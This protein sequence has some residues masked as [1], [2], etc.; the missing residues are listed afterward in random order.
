MSAVK[1]QIIIRY[2]AFLSIVF[3]QMVI[4]GWYCDI[5]L[6]KSIIP[7]Y[8]SMKLNTAIGLLLS[9]IV[10][11]LLQRE[12]RLWGLIANLISIF[13]FILGFTTLLQYILNVDFKIDELL[14]SDMDTRM[15]SGINPGRMSYSTAVCLSLFGLAFLGIRM[16]NKVAKLIAQNLL[17]AITLMTFIALI[18]YIYVIPAFYKWSFLTSMALHTATVMFILSIAASLFNPHFGTTGLFTRTMIGNTMARKL[19]PMMLAMVL[20]LGYL[21]LISHK[22]NLVSVEFGIALYGLSFLLVG[23]LLIAVTARML[24]NSDKKRSEAE[25]QL[26]QLN[27]NLEVTIRKRTTELEQSLQL[28]EESAQRNKIFVTQSPNAIAMFDNDM[29]YLAA[30]GKWYEDYQIIGRDIIGKS[31]YDVF[32]EIGDD[33]KAIHKDCLKGG[34]NKCD[35]AYF[36]RGD[37]AEQWITW[38]VR[39]WYESENK[40][41]GIIMY[42]AEI[43]DIK[44]KEIDKR[45]IE[46]ILH[47]SNS[48]ALIG[49]WESNLLTGQNTWSDICKDIFEVPFDFEPQMY[50]IVD[51]IKHKDQKAEL[52]VAI[53]E[54]IE[55]ETFYDMECEIVTH[56]GR[57]GWV[58]IIGQS[59]SVNNVTIKHFGLIQD[60]TLQK[61]IEGK[62]SISEE[63][64]RGAFEN[65][66]IGIALVSTE[67]K[68]LKINEK[69]SG[70]LGYSKEELLATTFQEITHPDDLELDLSKMHQLLNGEINKYSI[71][72][73]YFKK[74]GQIIW[75]LLNVSL[76]RDADN[77]PLHF[78]SQIE[79]I[80]VR[81]EIEK[82]L[83]D[84]NSDLTAILDSGN[85]SIISTDTEGFITHFNK[86]AELM[87]GYEASEMI[88]ISPGILHQPH[89][90]KER[91]EALSRVF[92]RPIKGF[93][94]FVEMARQGLHDSR[95]WT[96][97]RKDGTTFPVQLVVSPIKNGKGEIKGFLGI[98]TDIS[99]QVNSQT[100]LRKAKEELEMLADKLTRQNKQLQNFAHITA[101]NLRSP[102]SN[103][104]SLLELYHTSKSDDDKHVIFGHFETVANH[105]TNTL[106][107]LMQALK[108]RDSHQV[109]EE[110]NL[111]ETVNKIGEI[112]K[113]EILSSGAII[114]VDFTA[115]DTI[116]YNKGYMESIIQNLVSN[117]IKYKQP[118]IQPE[119]EIRSR[120]KDDLSIIEFKDNGLGID[121][122]QH[123]DK[124]FGLHKTFH[125]HKDAKGLGL[126]IVKNQI[127]AMGGEIQ[128]ESKVNQGTTFYIYLKKNKSN[129]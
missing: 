74:D 29:R 113:G 28:L 31:H 32:P 72:K 17:H 112:L 22:Y 52:M 89:E 90:I 107:D 18:G 119:I 39:P 80:T 91:G 117:S 43:S 102:A 94:I 61:N 30:S 63:E 109:F 77:K 6:L 55:N 78:V 36:V 27:L 99:E 98:A 53:S 47:K 120:I 7:D 15:K 21:R 122:G 123:G 37:G 68:W 116:D 58:R 48:I 105:L 70:F 100:Q 103:L 34:I 57:D 54:S 4:L 69:I 118:N 67:G 26:R 86:G 97:V 129:E 76:V 126:F 82:N 5:P 110:V 9:G 65:S 56:N 92:K 81:K 66:A 87:L 35:E 10:V 62:L 13:I 14:I 127:D 111:Y 33:W 16:H 71:E 50:S 108:I 121:L 125:R 83:L 106:N 88:G 23:L 20:I 42:T 114:S 60:I 40:I 73:R 104:L 95:K 59:E 12:K 2:S 11:L 8:N 38:D 51:Y 124:I 46:D 3:G 93:S 41:G 1:N 96:Y 19:F 128:V 49:A 79:D 44:K 45:K 101:H 24:N 25:E 64:F 75:I 115:F 85:V 84:L